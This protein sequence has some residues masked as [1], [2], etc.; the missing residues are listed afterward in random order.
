MSTPENVKDSDILS[1]SQR[2]PDR[3]IPTRTWYMQISYLIGRMEYTNRLAQENPCIRS[4]QGN[5]SLTNAFSLTLGS[6]PVPFGVS[7]DHNYETQGFPY[8]SKFQKLVEAQT[9]AGQQHQIPVPPTTSSTFFVQE[10]S[11]LGLELAFPSIYSAISFDFR[12]IRSMEVKRKHQ[13]T[14][15]VVGIFSSGS[16]NPNELVV[17]VTNPKRLFKQ[18]RW[19]V[20]RLRGIRGT[21]LSLRHVKGFRLYKVCLVTS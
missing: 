14:Y 5:E 19:A 3:Q 16:S 8:P 11:N 2:A 17:F 4:Q 12:Y 6:S 18:L 7:G 1:L 13:P 9:P 10:Q 15:V 21:V 20:F